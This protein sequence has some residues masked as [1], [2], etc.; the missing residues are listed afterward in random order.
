MGKLR[1]SKIKWPI[2]TQTASKGAESELEPKQPPR[3]NK[4]EENTIHALNHSQDRTVNILLEFT[5]G[6]AGL[7]IPL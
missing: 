5:L 1:F 4:S 7:P 3:Q 6:R 2:Y